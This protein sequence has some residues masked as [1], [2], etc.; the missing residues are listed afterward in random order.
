MGQKRG[1]HIFEVG[2][3]VLP[4]PV[5]FHLYK[6]INDVKEFGIILEIINPKHPRNDYR[7]VRVFWQQQMREE[8]YY[9]HLL[10][11][12]HHEEAIENLNKEW[13]KALGTISFGEMKARQLGPSTFVDE[14]IL[15][16]KLENLIDIDKI[17]LK[18][19]FRKYY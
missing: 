9:A 13:H 18:N 5:I 11:H 16:N 14:L 10:F 2:E 12:L 15:K 6:D 19:P 8:T 7:K 3:L 17:P 4:H 1:Q